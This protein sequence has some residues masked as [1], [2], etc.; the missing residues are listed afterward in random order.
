MMWNYRVVIIVPAASKPAAEQAARAINSTGPDY[1]GEA[2]TVALSA[3]G[4]QP[5]THYALYTS[6]TDEMVTAMAT[7]LPS[8]SGVQFWRHGVGGDLQAS[9]VTEPTGQAW[10]WAESLAA[11]GLAIV[12]PAV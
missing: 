5:A 8:L 11:A 2:F 12:S 9:N 6:A 10:G 4:S 7:A 3:G 1:Q